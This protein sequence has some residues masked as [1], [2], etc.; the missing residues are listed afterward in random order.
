MIRLFLNVCKTFQKIKHLKFNDYDIYLCLSADSDSM[1]DSFLCQ[2]CKAPSEMLVHNGSYKRHLVFIDNGCVKD[3]FI[4]IKTFKCT[5]C[6]KCHS[7]LYSL[8]I[9]H[10]PYSIHFI[11]DLIYRRLTRQFKN[12]QL[13]CEFYDITERT[14][15]RI[16]NRLLM[17]SKRMN[18]LLSTFGDLLQTVSILFHSESL[19]L[20][21]TLEDFFK[22]CGY[23][24]L[25]PCITFR[26]RIL[27]RG[28]SPG[29][30]R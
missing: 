22:S 17:D 23:S 11:I 9:P 8:I 26:Q 1:A 15:Y 18:A 30:I 29:G 6:S 20:H 13:L 24:F 27:T 5:S 2:S 7:L 19:F 12:I 14:F 10:S 21:S 28:I 4:E 25:Q 16:W 3:K